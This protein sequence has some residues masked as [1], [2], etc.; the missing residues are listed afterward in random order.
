V[1]GALVDAGDLR[2][3]RLRD[4]DAAA[5]TAAGALSRGGGRQRVGAQSEY[6]KAAPRDTIDVSQLLRPLSSFTAYG[7]S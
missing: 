1:A 3:L 5:S 4:V 6:A 7:V 2:D